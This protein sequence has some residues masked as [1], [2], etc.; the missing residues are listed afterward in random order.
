MDFY[1][2][3]DQVMSLLQERGRTSYRALTVQFKLDKESLK[4]LKEEILYVYS[5]VVTDD[6]GRGLIWTGEMQSPVKSTSRETDKEILYP[7]KSSAAG[8]CIAQCC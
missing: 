3:L 2:V 6:K 4:T 7:R 8:A 1:E 5:S